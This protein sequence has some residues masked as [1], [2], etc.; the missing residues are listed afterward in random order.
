MKYPL[1][2]TI[3]EPCDIKNFK[4]RDLYNL[5]DEIR[6]L[7]INTVS[8]NGGHLASNLGVVELSIALHKAFESPKD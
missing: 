4:L 3:S 8:H 1:L 5:A 2:S 6:T 7:I